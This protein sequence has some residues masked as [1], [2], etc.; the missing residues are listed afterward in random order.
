MERLYLLVRNDLSVGYQ[1]AQCAHVAVQWMIEHPNGKWQNDYII[2][3]HVKNI[4]KWIYKLD[5]LGEKYVT[6]HEP[7]LDN[8]LTAIATQADSKYF[9]NLRLVGT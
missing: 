1:A 7:D 5:H 6:F 3:L 2:L 8:E 9:K 4:Q